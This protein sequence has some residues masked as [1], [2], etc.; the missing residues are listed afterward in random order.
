M[1]KFIVTSFFAVVA[2]VAQAAN[3]EYSIQINGESGDVFDQLAAGTHTFTVLAEVTDNDLGGTLGGGGLLQYVFNIDESGDA[4]SFTEGSGGF[5]PAPNGLWMSTSAA[6]GDFTS[7]F[8][9]TLNANGSDVF[10][11][12]G[13]INPGQFSN[14][15]QLFGVGG[16]SEL[17]SGTFEWDGT[18]TTLTVTPGALSGHIVFTNDNGTFGGATPDAGVGASVLLGIPEPATALIAGLG[19]IGFAARR[20]S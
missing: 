1:L 17:V 7:F 3:V 8:P 2:C 13:G 15:A 16:P 20:R 11:E 4:V 10:G 12:T 19:V 18:P 5:P 6:P 9:G 14:K